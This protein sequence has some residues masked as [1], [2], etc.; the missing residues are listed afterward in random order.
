MSLKISQ[1]FIYPVKSLGGISIERSEVTDRGLAYDRRWMLVDE[2]NQFLT[3]REYPK[4]TQLHLEI[5]DS[6]LQIKSVE[7]D[8]SLKI[9]FDS[10]ENALEKATIWNA[11]VL[12]Y[13]YKNVVNEWFGDVLGG[14]CKLVYMPDSSYRPVDTT[15]GYHPV[16]KQVSFADAYP[17][18]LLSEESMNDLNTRFEEPMSILRFRPNIVFQGGTAYQEDSMNDF[19]INGIQFTG[20]ENCARCGIPNVNPLDGTV[21]PLKEPLRSLSKYRL[22]NKNIEFGRNVV[23][24]NTGFIQVGDEINV[25]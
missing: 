6:G 1:L 3:I 10:H 22:R 18:L 11:D 17:F 7:Q 12:A 19:S 21:H 13:S 25:F 15:S 23:H 16:D 24:S 5:L 20:L 2:N 8:T 4:M 9:S 14:K